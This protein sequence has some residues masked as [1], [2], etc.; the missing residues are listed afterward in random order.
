MNK[1]IVFD[2]QMGCIIH[3]PFCINMCDVFMDGAYV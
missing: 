1:G 2:G 3:E